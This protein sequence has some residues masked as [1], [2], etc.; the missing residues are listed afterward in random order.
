LTIWNIRIA[1]TRI[2][3]RRV[4]D[5]NGET[6]LGAI[7]T[8][9][10]QSRLRWMAFAIGVLPAVLKVYGSQGI[11]WSQA[12]G[13]MYLASWLLFEILLS[14]ARLDDIAFEQINIQPIT[15]PITPFLHR[16]CCVAA[17]ILHAALYSLPVAYFNA[18][19]TFYQVISVFC[20][21]PVWNQC[22][23]SLTQPPPWGNMGIAG[24]M[25]FVAYVCVVVL[26]G[27]TIIL[28]LVMMLAHSNG[29]PSPM[30]NIILPVCAGAVMAIG[31]VLYYQGRMNSLLPAIR[32]ADAVL[33]PFFVY[34]LLY[35]PAG[36]YQPLWFS[37]FG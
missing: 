29:E 35:D 7:R 9:V 11:P 26:A 3:S 16:C 18:Y 17:V 27:S 5:G 19:G 6:D 1:A 37:W 4:V 23:L 8:A 28:P 15:P 21:F 24:I 14:T 30:F 25:G 22:L 12:F 34:A 33:Y 36:T 31:A 2:L 10:A 20:Y 13:T 32:V